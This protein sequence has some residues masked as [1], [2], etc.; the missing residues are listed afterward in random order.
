VSLP[1]IRENNLPGAENDEGNRMSSS[2]GFWL[3]QPN[4]AALE[5]AA[6]LG[7]RLVIIDMEHGVVTAESCNALV[8]QA[9][10]LGLTVLVRVA[11][12]ERVLVQQA[13]DYGA[14]A[15]MLPM[16]RDAAHAADAAA[17]AKYPPLGTRGVGTGRAFGYGA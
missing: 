15:V 1:D 8:A 9:R 14:D 4:L 2:P 16:I 10:T 17:Y 12:A 3:E 13:L 6:L 7:Y 11:A 5:I